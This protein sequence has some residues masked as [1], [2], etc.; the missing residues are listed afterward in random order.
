METT[1][2]DDVLLLYASG[3]KGGTTEAVLQQLVDQS[4][5]QVAVER[6]SEVTAQ[7]RRYFLALDPA[8]QAT[9]LARIAAALA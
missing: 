5:A 2:A 1:P 4:L 8:G 6:F 9:E 3:R 7:W